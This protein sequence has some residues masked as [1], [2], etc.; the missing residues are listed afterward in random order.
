MQ[1]K[2][3]DQ[4]SRAQLSWNLPKIGS[5]YSVTC[6]PC[7]HVAPNW[8][9][10]RTIKKL[11]DKK[12]CPDKTRA[13]WMNSSPVTLICQGWTS[14]LLIHSSKRLFF[15]SWLLVTDAGERMRI[16]SIE[17]EKNIFLLL[18]CSQKQRVCGD[19]VKNDKNCD[20]S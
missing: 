17:R 4:L 10:F 16:A 9:L 14:S 15:S 8:H 6:Q 13:K 1:S 2:P 11:A 7:L 5:L 20:D 18:A 12:P 19:V 3:R